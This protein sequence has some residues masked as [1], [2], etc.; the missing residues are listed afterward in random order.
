M[1]A[2]GRLLFVF[3]QFATGENFSGQGGYGNRLDQIL[4]IFAAQVYSSE[5][6]TGKSGRLYIYKDGCV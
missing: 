2:C 4:K 5:S 1:S 6:E 3:R